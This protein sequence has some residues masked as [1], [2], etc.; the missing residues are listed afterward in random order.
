ML[1][2]PPRSSRRG[3]R[4]LAPS[5]VLRKRHDQRP[6]GAGDESGSGLPRGPFSSRTTLGRRVPSGPDDLLTQDHDLEVLVGLALPAKDKEIEQ[7]LEHYIKEGD[8]HGPRILPTGRLTDH[9]AGSDLTNRVSVPHGCPAARKDLPRVSLPDNGSQRSPQQAVPSLRV[10][11]LFM[12]D[13]INGPSKL[14]WSR[15]RVRDLTDSGSLG[16]ATEGV[17][18]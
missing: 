11:S 16:A 17:T 1:A 13:D 6:T 8:H 2:R 3:A 10:G 15:A 14:L 12:P 4:L 9:P 5:V 18:T 7:T